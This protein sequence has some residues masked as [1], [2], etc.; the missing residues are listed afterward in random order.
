MSVVDEGSVDAIGVEN[1]TGKVVLTISDHLDWTDAETHTLA[2]QEKLNTYLAFVESGEIV[3]SYPDAAGRSVAFD[4]V[5][6]VAPD[7]RGSMFL[8][9]VHGVV[10][11]A[12][13]EMRYRLLGE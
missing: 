4:L 8:S 13:I 2:L 7:A 10:E 11:G 3:E 12:G 6:R 1:A 5:M 9:R